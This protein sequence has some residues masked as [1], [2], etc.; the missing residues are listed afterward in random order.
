MTAQA[1]EL[2]LPPQLLQRG[3]W[4]YV[5]KVVGPHDEQLCY[6]GMTG[7]VT[8]VAQSP[9][10][11]VTSTLGNNK[12]A[13]TLRAALHARGVDPEHCKGLTLAAYG[14]LYDANDTENYMEHWHK[15]RAL[16]RALFDALK[17]EGFVPVNKRRPSGRPD[18]DAN[19]FVA[20][21]SAFASH[22]P[23]A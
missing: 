15:V 11:R 6:V 23:H 13:N 8:R 16:E 20:I 5:W 1:W 19:L 17:E 4:I 2:S 14:P 18:Y 21:R 12:N 22:F 3:F 7:D 9:F 10:G